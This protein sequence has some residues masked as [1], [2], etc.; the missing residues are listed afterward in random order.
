MPLKLTGGSLTLSVAALAIA[1]TIRLLRD[2][3]RCRGSPTVPADSS[4][5]YFA[6]LSLE[7]IALL[8]RNAAA[9]NLD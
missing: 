4:S 7:A 5:K 8:V 1:W 9:R 6:E 2:R 3:R